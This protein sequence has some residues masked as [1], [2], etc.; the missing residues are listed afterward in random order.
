[1]TSRRSFILTGGA[2]LIAGAAALNWR[3]VEAAPTPAWEVTRTD[4]EWRALLSPAQY[5]ILRK[6]GTERPFSSPLYKE[7]R[8]GKFFC[9]G[10]QNPL[11]SSKTKFDSGTG[12]PSFWKP[13][14]RGVYTS[15]TTSLGM[16]GAEVKCRRC[17]S[18][19]GDVFDDGPE[20]TG[21]RYCI[22]GLA[23][24]FTPGEA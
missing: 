21:L 15:R 4:A 18:H 1:M 14:D 8:A 23:L 20:P 16:M 2:A 7:H 3:A 6:G 24:T 19:L 13:L 12:W 10:C 11:F 5:D 9:A 22:D 17:G